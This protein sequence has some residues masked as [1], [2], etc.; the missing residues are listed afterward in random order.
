MQ[1]TK[2][3]FPVPFFILAGAV[4]FYSLFK[5]YTLGIADALAWIGVLATSLPTN[6]F[7]LSLLSKQF[8]RTKRNL[9]IT[10]I[11]TYVGLAI[12]IVLS[13]STHVILPSI[14]ALVITVGLITYIYWYSLYDNFISNKIAIN[15]PLPDFHIYTQ[16]G[17]RVNFSS[18]NQDPAL[19]L[20]FRGNWCPLCMVQI[21]EVVE[22]YK[23]LNRRGV[24]VYLIGSQNEKH[25][26]NLA[27]KFDVPMTFLADK[28]NEAGK[29][30]DL[31]H[32]DGT[33]WGMDM[34]GYNK[35]TLLPTVIMTNKQGNV[36][37]FEQTDNYRVRP[38][39]QFFLNA[40]DRLVG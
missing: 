36:V 3:Y 10:Q 18:L 26:A 28:N 2:R 21:Q 31:T 1:A 11:M 39:P 12:T 29:I 8:A 25:T 9:P 22:S 33:P 32:K 24:S 4:L 38:E 19:L 13:V 27:K 5:I 16:T 37:M 15:E 14:L 23:E 35:D 34:L 6:I 17:E 7:V 40:Y 30:L 20:F